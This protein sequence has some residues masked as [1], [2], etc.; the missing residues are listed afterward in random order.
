[1][2]VKQEDFQDQSIV[3]V[4]RQSKDGYRRGRIEL[5]ALMQERRGTRRRSQHVQNSKSEAPPHGSLGCKQ[6]LCDKLRGHLGHHIS[7]QR[8]SMFCSTRSVEYLEEG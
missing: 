5:D 6:R 2:A 4:A 7:I 8:P 1:M 3:C